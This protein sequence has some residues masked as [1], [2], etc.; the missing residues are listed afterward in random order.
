MLPELTVLGVPPEH[1]SSIGRSGGGSSKSCGGGGDGGSA[2]VA[3]AAA[4]GEA[5]NSCLRQTANSWNVIVVSSRQEC[6]TLA[7]LE[8]TSPSIKCSENAKRKNAKQK[9]AVV[10]NVMSFYL[11]S[12]VRYYETD[13]NVLYTISP[14][15]FSAISIDA[16]YNNSQTSLPLLQSIIIAYFADMQYFRC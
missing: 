9:N 7:G 16:A 12:L 6:L 1:L 10:L 11:C 13:G 5:G 4:K 3:T 2:A 15:S 8:N 14:L